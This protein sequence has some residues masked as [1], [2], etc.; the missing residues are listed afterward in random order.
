MTPQE[1]YYKAKA[2]NLGN[3]MPEIEPTI[4]K[5]AEYSY[6]YA[7]DIIKGK[8]EL[9]E[10]IISKYVY[11]SY[12]YATDV[13]EGKLPDFMHNQMILENNE[14]A[15]QYIEFISKNP[16]SPNNKI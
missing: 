8:W 3:R 9:G 11:W 4:I 16:N 12:L 2:Y 10:P 6:L 7:R 13:I 1:A 15:K 14:Y 5:D